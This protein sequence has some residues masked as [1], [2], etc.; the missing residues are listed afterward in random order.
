MS[1]LPSEPKHIFVTGGAGYIGSHTCVELLNSGYDVTVY[2]NFSNSHPEAIRRVEII[3]GKKVK[4]FHGDI[5]D[6]AKLLSVMQDSNCD[7]IIHFA[8]LKAVGE[9]VENPIEYYD[10]NVQGTLCLLRAMKFV[11]IERFIFSS[12]ATVYGKPQFLPLTED[13]PLSATN[14]YGRSKL[15][16]EEI[17]RDVF[18]SNPHLHIRILRYFNPVGAHESGMIGEDPRGV[19]NNLMPIICQVAVGRRDHLKIWG[20]DYSTPDGTGVRDF[21]HVVDLAVGHVRALETLDHPQC[22]SINLGTGRGN[23]VLEIIKE[24]EKISGRAIDYEFSSRRS[25]DIEAC[26]ASTELAS[27]LLNWRATRNIADMCRDSWS[28]RQSNPDGYVKSR[29]EKVN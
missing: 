17:L 14:P 20:N 25:G 11:G 7:S 19:P 28:W 6:E 29:I 12:S 21:I 9:S 2:D 15:F 23:S 3:T 1:K 8:G 5:R 18:V 13:H 10:N 27:D 16:I 24:F 4:V 22:V 26:F